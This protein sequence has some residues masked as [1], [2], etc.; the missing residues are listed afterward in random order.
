MVDDI[1]SVLGLREK[2]PLQRSGKLNTKEIAQRTQILYLKVQNR[3]YM[4]QVMAEGL[5]PIMIISST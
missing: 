1:I 5:E 4:T 3:C 2:I